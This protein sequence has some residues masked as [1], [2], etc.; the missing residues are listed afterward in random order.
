MGEDVE[1][2]K[3]IAFVEQ[4]AKGKPMLTIQRGDKQIL[5]IKD[6]VVPHNEYELE[7]L[8]SLDNHVYKVGVPSKITV[9]DAVYEVKE[10]DSIGGRVLIH[11]PTSNKDVWIGR[12][13]ESDRPGDNV[14]STPAAE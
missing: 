7:L 12:P 14:K 9:R 8:F 1:G 13:A 11:D 3:L 4:G 2:F 6:E 10:V 5:L